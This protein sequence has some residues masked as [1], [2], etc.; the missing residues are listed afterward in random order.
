MTTHPH[1][2][3]RSLREQIE[4]LPVADRHDFAVRAAFE[5]HGEVYD[6]LMLALNRLDEVANVHDR[7][8]RDMAEREVTKARALVE[9]VG[10]L[11]QYALAERDTH[12]ARATAAASD[13]HSKALVLWTKVLAFATASLILATVAAAFIARG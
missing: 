8:G 7:V 11:V 1:R 9:N 13:R 2:D 6:V 4:G 12:T 10:A 5:K 3:G